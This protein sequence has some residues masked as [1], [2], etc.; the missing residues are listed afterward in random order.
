MNSINSILASLTLNPRMPFWAIGI[1]L[2]FQTWMRKKGY[3]K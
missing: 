1:I 2:D 3:V